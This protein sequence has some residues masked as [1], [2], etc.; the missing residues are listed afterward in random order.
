MPR[1]IKGEQK[2]D[3]KRGG[4]SQKEERRKVREDELLLLTVVLTTTDLPAVK[5]NSG[6]F[7]LSFKTILWGILWWWRRLPAFIS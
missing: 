2:M 1:N 6:L 3:R 5:G 4:K 7:F